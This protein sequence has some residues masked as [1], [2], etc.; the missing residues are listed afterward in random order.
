MEDNKQ[1]VQAEVK[2]ETK[3]SY[4][5]R[6]AKYRADMTADVL[7]H[8]RAQDTAWQVKRELPAHMPVNPTTKHYFQKHALLLLEKM[9]ELGTNDPRFV[10]QRQLEEIGGIVIKGQKSITLESTSKKGTKGFTKY[11]NYSQIFP[12]KDKPRF[13]APEIYDKDTDRLAELMLQHNTVYIDKLTQSNDAY[14]DCAASAYQAAV[15]MQKQEAKANDAKQQRLWAIM[16]A[17]TTNPKTAEDIFMAECRKERENGT[18]TVKGTI[19]KDFVIKAVKNMLLK[20]IPE[21]DVRAAVTAKAPEAAYDNVAGRNRKY[22]D[23]VMNAVHKDKKFQKDFEKVH[24]GA[25]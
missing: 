25:R 4:E 14:F 11:F 17:D 10:T 24:G 15:I 5:E 21:K 7:T 16:K 8:M 13:G 3:I 12:A 6:K 2:Q 22:E 9:H 18:D 20:N 23:F 19:K 1:A